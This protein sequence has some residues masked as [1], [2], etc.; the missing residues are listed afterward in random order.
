MVMFGP[1]STFL[2]NA[3]ISLPYTQNFIFEC[4]FVCFKQ[5][6]NDQTSTVSIN[7]PKTQ[8]LVR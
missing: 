3:I 4:I 8:S 5:K 6:L 1:E 7:P 2:F